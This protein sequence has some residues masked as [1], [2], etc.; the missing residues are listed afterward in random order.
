MIVDAALHNHNICHFPNILENS[1]QKG[2]KWENTRSLQHFLFFSPREQKNAIRSLRRVLDPSDVFF[3]HFTPLQSLRVAT[4]EAEGCYV[5]RSATPEGTPAFAPDS[6][7]LAP[8]ST[9]LRSCRS[10]SFVPKSR[11]VSKKVFENEHFFC[12]LVGK[13]KSKNAY[14][15]FKIHHL[16]GN[17]KLTKGWA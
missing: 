8:D 1:T 2:L 6:T 15:H 13:K 9:T 7:A 5:L 17:L 10:I 16:A 4:S 12:S 14:Y 11:S 3:T